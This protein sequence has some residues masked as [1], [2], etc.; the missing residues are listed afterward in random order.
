MQ[1]PRELDENKMKEMKT[2]KRKTAFISFY[3]FFG[4]GTFQKV[5]LD[6]NKKNSSLFNS[7]SRLCRR[8]SNAVGSALRS[9]VIRWHPT[10]RKS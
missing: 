9:L 2:N 1:P 4:I 6:S 7:P 3:F 5:T 10:N 8:A